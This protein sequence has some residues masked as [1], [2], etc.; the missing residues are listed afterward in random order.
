MST[1][2]QT[3]YKHLE[4]LLRRKEHVIL[5]QAQQISALKQELLL[6]QILLTEAKRTPKI[7][8]ALSKTKLNCKNEDAAINVK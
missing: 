6:T 8:T 3:G 1:S 4:E 7:I 2:S 5:N